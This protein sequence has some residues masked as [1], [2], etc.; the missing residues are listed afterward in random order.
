MSLTIINKK[1]SLA[2]LAY[3]FASP[4]CCPSLP[5]HTEQLACSKCTWLP[6]SSQL[7]LSSRVLLLRN[8]LTRSSSI[9]SLL[10][11]DWSSWL[12]TLGPIWDP[13]MK[14]LSVKS[15]G[16]TFL[17]HSICYFIYWV[18][19]LFL[20]GF[21]QHSHA[22]QAGFKLEILFLSPADYRCAWT[23]RVQCRFFI[24]MLLL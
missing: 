21:P 23:H 18:F 22:S 1:P 5:R 7:S 4:S 13:S 12:L 2:S 20:S 8:Y 19:K 6:A 14:L 16:Y 3:L 9:T 15:S 10:H 24:I 11:S 17:S